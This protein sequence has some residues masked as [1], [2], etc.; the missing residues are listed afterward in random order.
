[1]DDKEIKMMS[2]KVRTE[3]IWRVGTEK[4]E[5]VRTRSFKGLGSNRKKDLRTNKKEMSTKRIEVAKA[6]KN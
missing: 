2:K 5:E 4:A 1:M 3:N 6:E